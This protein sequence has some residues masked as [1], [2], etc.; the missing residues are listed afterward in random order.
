MGVSKAEW[1]E[2]RRSTAAGS[3][4]TAAAAREAVVPSAVI[5]REVPA[6]PKGNPTGEVR[7]FIYF[8]LARPP[9]AMVPESSIVLHFLPALDPLPVSDNLEV[10]F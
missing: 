9:C 5:P 8:L 3:Q 10:V 2:A 1:L 6:L 4:Q 7:L